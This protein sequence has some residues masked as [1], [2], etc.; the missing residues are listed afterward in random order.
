MT[1]SNEFEALRCFSEH[2]TINGKPICYTPFGHNTFI[3][4]VMNFYHDGVYHLMYMPDRHHHGN[5]WGC[6]AHHFEH[7]I[8]RDFVNWEGGLSLYGI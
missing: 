1:F 3:D 8:T 2:N 5:R 6:G 4:D 7:M